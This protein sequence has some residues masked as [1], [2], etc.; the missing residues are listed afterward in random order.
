MAVRGQ[1]QYTA[2]WIAPTHG[3]DVTIKIKI[4]TCASIK[5]WSYR[6]ITANRLSY[7]NLYMNNEIRETAK[8]ACMMPQFIIITAL[9]PRRTRQHGA[10]QEIFYNFN[11]IHCRTH[12]SRHWTYRC[13]HPILVVL[14]TPIILAEEYKL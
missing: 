7:P 11:E 12:K 9:I 4:A 2:G 8:C 14:I 3:V 5:P 10:G 6:F 1:P 13:A